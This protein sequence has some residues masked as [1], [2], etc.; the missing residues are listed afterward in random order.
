MSHYDFL[1]VGCGMFG[2]TFAR[3]MAERGRKV[4]IIEKRPHPGGNCY[5]EDLE[6]IQVHKYGPHIFHTGIDRVWKYVNR[7]A[8]FNAFINRPKVRYQNKLYSFPINLMTLYQLWGTQSPDE[9][10]K[11]LE[12][13]VVENNDPRHLEDWILS[14]VGREIYEVF[15]K[16]YT[17][18][19]WGK[20]P[21]EL[22]ASII[23]RVPVRLNFNDNY[24]NDKYQ[25]IPV[26]GYTKLFEKM[27]EG[28]EVKLNTDYFANRQY[29][30]SAADTIVYTGKID[31]YFNYKFG[32]LEYRGLRF[33]SKLMEGDYQG[34]AVIN[35]TEE[36]VPYT[37]I[38]EHKH[39]ELR[40]TDK[41]AV[42]WE[43]PDNYDKSKIPYY[44]VN[45]ERNNQ[46][47]NLYRQEAARQKKL[48]LGG[49]LAAYAYLDMDQTIDAALTTC[50][51]IST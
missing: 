32:E 18:K 10:K 1:V 30:D 34:N 12:E 49:R 15:F 42:T 48:I 37:R 6:N 17:K 44:P 27:L 45:V 36:Q 19:Q 8:E 41:T 26:G 43:Y 31:E 46:L 4:L 11:K 50:E 38:I 25:G 40:N 29:W 22:P 20:D 9:A 2:A 14:R 47:Y 51:R 7:F 39:F 33:E 23:Q 5:T 21:K 3:Q 28:V 16:G 35:Y 24:Y 13:A